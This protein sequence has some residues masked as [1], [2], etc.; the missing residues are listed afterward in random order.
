MDSNYCD[1]NVILDRSGSM[2]VVREGLI[3][4]FN[5]WVKGQRDLPGKCTLTLTQ[6]DSEGTDILYESK[7]IKEVPGLE[8]VPRGSTPLMD[9]IGKAVASTKE[10]YDS[11]Y[12]WQRPGKVMFVVITDGQ[13]NASH[14]FKKDQVK[15]LVE[16]QKKAGWEFI[17]LGVGI[18]AFAE[19]SQYGFN[20]GTTRSYTGGV[21]GMSMAMNSLNIGT[22]SYRTKGV[23][24]LD[25][26]QDI[27]KQN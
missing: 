5:S 2:S 20:A 10:R 16:Q 13:E 26:Q 23:V 14:E 18:D 4:E 22:Q 11:L 19:A 25:D 27:D 24:E 17:F 15:A 12:S 6:F 21:R 3:K 1:I 7:D 8:F 9:A